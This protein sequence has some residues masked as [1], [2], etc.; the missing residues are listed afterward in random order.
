MGKTPIE[1]VQGPD[2][3]AGFSANPIR[4]RRN[5]D[6]PEVGHY[7]EKI[8]PGCAHCYASTLQKRF[9]MPPFPG[10]T[11]DDQTMP[12]NGSMRNGAIPYLD[13][14]VLQQIRRRRKP[15][16]YFI[17]D[18]TDVFGWWVRDEWLDKMFATF[19]QCPQ[20]T[21]MLLTKRP[22]RMRSYFE[23]LAASAF[24]HNLPM[25][26][27]WLGVS[28]ENQ[29]TWDERVPIL[30]ATP[31]AVRFV[32]VE[33]MLGPVDF[34]WPTKFAYSGIGWIIYGG[35]SGHGARPCNV[36]WIRDGLRQCKAAGV[37]AFVKQLGA[38]PYS[39]TS[40][41]IGSIATSFMYQRSDARLTHPKG[42]DPGEWPEGLR[43]REFPR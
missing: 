1:W 30:A 33:P 3:A 4:A 16:R 19:W 38:R 40:G 14:T 8:S 13:E 39:E 26:N 17:G 25:P 41:Q 23:R 27:C 6:G 5:D 35:E 9:R 43:I 37:P 18:M 36:E 2:G 31:A 32:S 28:A 22:E 24:G 15:T 12:L 21:F 34:N 29:K 42:G 20:H 11:R 10:V 7:C